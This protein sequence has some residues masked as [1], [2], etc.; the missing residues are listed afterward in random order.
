MGIYYLNNGEKGWEADRLDWNHHQMVMP[1][2]GNT[3]L[4]QEI[5]KDLQSLSS[6]AIADMC[7]GTGVWAISVAEELP[8]AHIRGFD[9]DTSKFATNLPSHVQLQYGDVFGSFPSELLGKFDLVHA[10]FLVSL[11]RKED[12]VPVARNFMTLLRPGGWILWEDSGPFEFRVLPITPGWMKYARLS[13]SFCN[14]NGMDLRM[15]ATLVTHLEEAGF[16]D[17]IG[18][19]FHTSPDESLDIGTKESM[20]RLAYQTFLGMVASG[21]VEEMKTEAQARVAVDEI[22]REFEQGTLCFWTLSRV[23]GKKPVS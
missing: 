22:R 20:L 4:P 21:K 16:V 7:T 9:I 17:V 23:W 15:P 3:V 14:A 10:R 12:W 8:H 18:K 2:V 19:D 11:L 6:P 5:R 1:L 13:W